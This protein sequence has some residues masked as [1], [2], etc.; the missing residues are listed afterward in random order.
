[1]TTTEIII[2]LAGFAVCTSVLLIAY[3][4]KLANKRIDDTVTKDQCD[5][6]REQEK[7]DMTAINTK[8]CN[9]DHD[10]DGKVRVKL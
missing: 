2:S 10:E 8:L 9:H 5:E 4:W 6:R 1:M 7:K 3:I